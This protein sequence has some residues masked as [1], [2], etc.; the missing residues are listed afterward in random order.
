MPF[1]VPPLSSAFLLPAPAVLARFALPCWPYRSFVVFVPPQGCAPRRLPLVLWRALRQAEVSVAWAAHLGVTPPAHGCGRLSKAPLCQ[2]G[3]LPVAEVGSA[4]VDPGPWRTGLCPQVSSGAWIP[5]GVLLRL[6][7]DRAAC[8][9][10]AGVGAP[11]PSGLFGWR[12]ES[13]DAPRTGATRG[14]SCFLLAFRSSGTR[15]MPR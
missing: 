8:S 14:S 2:R 9:A 15:V 11:C 7:W 4:G 12:K 1:V 10:S 13:E 5:S 6:R 3:P